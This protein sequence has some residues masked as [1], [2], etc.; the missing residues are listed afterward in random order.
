M[1]QPPY[2]ALRVFLGVFC[3][4]V[5][6][7]GLVMILAGKPL[8]MRLLLRPPQ[9]ELSGLALSLLKE[10]GGFMLMISAM[11]FLVARDPARNAAILHALIVGLCVLSVTPLVSLYMLDVG[12]IYPSY[13][14]WGRTVIRL[15]LAGVLFYL[16]PGVS[17]K[18]QTPN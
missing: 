1:S 12:H 14:F 10:F 16:R 15:V 18:A 2:R 4:V 6:V 5:T 3:L 8:F 13:F 7:G 17:T 11:L 9:S